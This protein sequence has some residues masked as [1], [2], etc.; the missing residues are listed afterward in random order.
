MIAPVLDE[1]A[2][3]YSGRVTIAKVNVDHEQALA[4]Q[5]GVTAIPT[6]ILFHKGQVAEQMRGLRSKRD[7]KQT[8]DRVAA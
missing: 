5:Y 3:E 1:L 6:L 8:F 2:E 7:L 4:A